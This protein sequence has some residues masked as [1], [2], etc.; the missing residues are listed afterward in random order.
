MP[1][2][3]MSLTCHHDAVLAAAATA[4]AVP[5]LD[6]RG[7]PPADTE[8]V[9]SGIGISAFR[10]G[11]NVFCRAI[12]S[13]RSWP[14]SGLPIGAATVI[15]RWEAIGQIPPG[16][17]YS[18]TATTATNGDITISS[19]VNLSRTGGNGCRFIVTGVSVTT[20]AYTYNAANSQTTAT[21]TW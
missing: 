8:M 3:M 4:A 7:P 17:P 10:S 14:N 20:A 5:S 9:V 1:L 13:V 21:R 19:T 6:N 11:G 16:W 2:K 15:F 18:G 12:V